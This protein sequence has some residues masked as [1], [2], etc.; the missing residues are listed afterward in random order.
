MLE[1]K[2]KGLVVCSRVFLLTLITIFLCVNAF[3]MCGSCGMGAEKKQKAKNM[4][5][6][7]A[8]EAKVKDGVKEISYEQFMEIRNTG[9]KY[10]LVDVLSKESYNKGHIDGAISFPLETIEKDAAKKQLSKNDHIIVYCGSFQCMASTEAAKRLSK[11]GYNVIDYKGGL[12]DWQGKGNSLV[13]K[14]K[15]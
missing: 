12:K 8:N 13:S 1:Y 15:K 14:I 6:H 5:S 3:A 7:V 9:E 10:V 11:L 2:N 4:F